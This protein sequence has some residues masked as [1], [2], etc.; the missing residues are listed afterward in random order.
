MALAIK[1]YNLGRNQMLMW[2]DIFC[3]FFLNTGKNESYESP[4]FPIKCGKGRVQNLRRRNLLY[5]APSLVVL[6][7]ILILFF[8][9]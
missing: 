4:T 9:S 3:I 6:I 1:D 5:L 8:S 2:E 7:A